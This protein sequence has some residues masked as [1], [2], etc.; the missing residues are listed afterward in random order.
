MSTLG[1][2]SPNLAQSA[3]RDHDYVPARLNW[4]RDAYVNNDL[5]C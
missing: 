3:A 2:S 5:R 4:Q 1:I